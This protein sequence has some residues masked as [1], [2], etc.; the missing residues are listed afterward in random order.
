MILNVYT[1][2]NYISNQ[3]NFWRFAEIPDNHHIQRNIK[4]Q[5]IMKIKDKLYTDDI[6]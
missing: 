6:K 3:I 1:D 4:K 5:S 2:E